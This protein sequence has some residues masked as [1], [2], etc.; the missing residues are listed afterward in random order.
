MRAMV[1]PS[2]RSAFRRRA[3]S[4]ALLA[5]LSIHASAQLR[6]VNYNVAQLNGDLDALQRVFAALNDDDKPGFAIA[7]A[8]YLFQ[9]VDSTDAAVPSGPLI[10]RLNAAAP[11]GVVYARATYT[12]INENGVGGAQCAFYRTDL[13]I[14]EPAGHTDI[15]TGAGRYTDRWRFRLV[16]YPAT[17]NVFYVYSSHLKAENTPTDAATRCTGAQAIRDNADQ[18]P[19]G[20]HI[21]YC[22]D[23]NVYN[24]AECAYLTFG[25][26]GN[27]QAIDPLGSGSW[28]GAPNAIKHTQSPCISNC[29]LVG[30]GLDD[31]F[32]HQH[33]TTAFNDGEGLA[34]ILGP[35]MY[36][37]FGNDGNHYNTDIGPTAHNGF[38]PNTY[39]PGDV[40]R[41]NA[42]AADLRVAS[43]HIPVVCEYQVPAVLVASLPA[44]FGRIIQGAAVSVQLA[45]SNGANVV[46]AA[47]ADELDYEATAFGILSGS[48]SGSVNAL[49][50]AQLRSFP[51]DSSVVGVAAGGI[52]VTTAS[53]GAA[54]P[55][56]VRNTSGTV[57][58]PSNPSLRA[59][60][61]VDVDEINRI[62]RRGTG[63]RSIPIAVTNFGFDSLQALLDVDSVAGLGPPFSAG[64]GLPTGIGA[65][66][67]TVEVWFD[68]NAVGDGPY[69]ATAVLSTSDE[70]L[71][72]ETTSALVVQ[73]GVRVRTFLGDVD[74][75]CDVELEDLTIV[76]SA[77]GTCNGDSRF[78]PAADVDNN[79]C[80]DLDDLTTLLAEFGSV[81]P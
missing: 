36:R 55:S 57:L 24:N 60:V 46:V 6:V 79:G 2:S 42:L 15:F 5:S 8:L 18:F 14:E 30:G 74:D 51:I 53:Q 26:A 43:D 48:A 62:F 49:A 31:R 73:L 9:E 38:L 69:A 58:R 3:I 28:A 56:L 65:A 27:G 29:S 22:G 47:G 4:A 72:G 19:A 71:P 78:D 7:P 34:R 50:P 20:T 12:N 54:N 70:D 80:V 76:L 16:N 63:L 68:S 32:D 1:V 75:D 61:D 10:T 81:C 25:A 35:H 40:A 41:S 59:A 44:S 37:A 13:L 45:V 67:V 23:W 33:A 21:I 17:D 64:P 39:Y 66:S 11:P 52:L 77:F